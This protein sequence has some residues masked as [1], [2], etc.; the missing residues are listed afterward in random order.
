MKDRQ[1]SES[2]GSLADSK[3][4]QLDERNREIDR[5]AAAYA[6]FDALMTAQFQELEH[7]FRHYAP[8]RARRPFPGRK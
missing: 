5:F 7:K 2:G 6:R 3:R 1:R 4:E 8:P